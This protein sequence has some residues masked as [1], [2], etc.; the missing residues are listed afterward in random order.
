MEI[1]CKIT[2]QATRNLKFL[3]QWNAAV[4]IELGFD[5]QV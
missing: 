5:V 3:N 2:N 1:T 4:K